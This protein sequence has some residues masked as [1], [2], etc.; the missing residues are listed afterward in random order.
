M[1]MWIN[2]QIMYLERCYK[3]RFTLK[4]IKQLTKYFKNKI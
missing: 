3:R 2:Y 4:E 1:T